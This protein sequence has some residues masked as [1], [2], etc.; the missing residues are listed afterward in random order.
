LP[1]GLTRFIALVV[2][3]LLEDYPEMSVDLRSGDALIDLV[4]EG[5]DLAVMPFAPTDSTLI[6]RTLAKW[7]HVLCAAPSY[8]ETHPAPRSPAD[9]AG[10]NFLL[11]AYSVYGP[12]FYFF[13]SAGNKLAARLSGNLVTTSVVVMRSAA[14][15]GL[16]LWLCPPYI[17]GDLLASGALVRLLPDYGTPEMEIVA[18]YPHRRQLSAKVRLFLDRLVDRFAEEQRRLYPAWTR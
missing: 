17:V 18:L 4:Q 12:E 9:L 7:H 2:T 13:D 16:G 11:Y 8:L 5:F 3:G 14:V 15:A 10:H 1:P 6:K